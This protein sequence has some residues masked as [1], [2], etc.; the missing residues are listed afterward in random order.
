MPLLQVVP[1][2]VE[3]GAEALALSVHQDLLKRG[4]LSSIVAL[5]GPAIEGSH[6][7]SL[8]APHPRHPLACW[9]LRKWITNHF[10]LGT[11]LIVHTHLFPDQ[12]WTPLA[13]KGLKIAPTLVTSL[14]STMTKRDAL[15]Y[16]VFLD[17]KLY[18]PYQRL[19]CV[20]SAVAAATAGR[21]PNYADRLHVIPNGVDLAQFRPWVGGGRDRLQMAIVGRLSPPKNHA[22]LLHALAEIRS[23]PFTLLIVGAG[24]L[25]AELKAL[26][27]RLSLNEKV[28]FLGYQSDIPQILSQ[29]DIHLMPS[30]FEGFGLSAV[31]A[32]A[33]GVP[34]VVSDL[35]ALREVLGEDGFCAFFAP[36]ND[37]TKFADTL[38]RLIEDPTLRRRMG[39][40]GYLRAQSYGRARMH[41]DY[42]TFYQ[43]LDAF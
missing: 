36:F 27:S 43:S 22:F 33:A 29:C 34:S 5:S 7:T 4:R 2:F 35:P 12:L 41:Q 32:M 40:N 39:M 11:K 25:D 37:T 10:P 15:P 24:A 28:R 23:L 17:R 13:L 16:G 8:G 30:L 38:R 9:R 42:A 26:A 21:L 20:S 3:G 18:A 6:C 1:R 31:E 14:H 19:I